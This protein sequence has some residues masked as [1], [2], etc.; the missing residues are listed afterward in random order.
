M[1]AAFLRML[2]R[3]VEYS[4]HPYNNTKMLLLILELAGHYEG[5]SLHTWALVLEL[6]MV[7]SVPLMTA[8]RLSGILLL[9]A[10]LWL[11]YNLLRRQISL[12]TDMSSKVSPVKST[13]EIARV[14]TWLAMDGYRIARH[15]V[16]TTI[17]TG[18]LASP[19]DIDA[20]LFASNPRSI[21][22]YPHAIPSHISHSSGHTHELHSGGHTNTSRPFKTFSSLLSLVHFEVSSLTRTAEKLTDRSEPPD[23]CVHANGAVR[24]ADVVVYENLR[25]GRFSVP[26]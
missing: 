5:P 8:A 7:T 16:F 19:A 2:M 18:A 9:S 14:N 20:P 25:I 10:Q 15:G 26:L 6:Y 3:P 22:S 23:R 13:P 1:M 4:I 24:S 21:S 12:G 17:A 11:G